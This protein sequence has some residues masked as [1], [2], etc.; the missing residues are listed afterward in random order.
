MDRNA[1]LQ[2]GRDRL[3]FTVT[4]V[5]PRLP[6]EVAVAALWQEVLGLGEIG[7]HD[8]FFE[9]GGESLQATQI[10]SR[11]RHATGVELPLTHFFEAPTVAELSARIESARRA[12]DI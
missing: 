4:F 8:N 10:M 9:L 12:A 7:V 6:M 11:V 3:A 2:L 5:P 1:L